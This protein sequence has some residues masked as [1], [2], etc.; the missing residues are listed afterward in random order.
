MANNIVY[1]GLGSN[2]DNLE[3]NLLTAQKEIA[4]I[5]EIIKK[6]SL[7]KTE[8]VNYKNQPDFLNFALVLSTELSAPDLILKLKEIERK[9]GRIKRIDQGPRLIDIDILFY[10]N[11]IINQSDL[12]IPHPELSQRSFVLTPLNEIDRNFIDPRS[13]KTINELLKELKN[14]EKVTLWT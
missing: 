12:R 8:P 10:N 2:I 3:Q 4:K 9:M 11:E 5:G 13:K 7:Y 1:L 14:H 6:S